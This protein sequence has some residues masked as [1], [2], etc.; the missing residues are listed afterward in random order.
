MHVRVVFTKPMVV[1]PMEKKKKRMVRDVRRLKR[2]GGAKW[3]GSPLARHIE[4]KGG[5]REEEK[6]EKK[7]DEMESGRDMGRGNWVRVLSFP[8]QRPLR[9]FKNLVGLRPCAGF[10][11]SR[12]LSPTNKGVNEL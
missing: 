11:F 10:F 1:S 4:D 7:K 12:L 2:E 5:K 6:K 8:G 3:A 9:R